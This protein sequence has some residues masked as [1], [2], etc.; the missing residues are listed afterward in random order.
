MNWIILST[1]LIVASVAAE[2]QYTD[3]YD[4]I[5]Y[6]EILANKRLLGPYIKCILDKGRCTAEGKELKGRLT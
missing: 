3:R 6:E 1:L 5:D 4:D 2:E